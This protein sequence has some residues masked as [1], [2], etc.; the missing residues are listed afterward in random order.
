MKD[1]AHKFSYICLLVLLPSI[2]VSTTKELHM[3]SVAMDIPAVMY[4]RLL[5]LTRYLEKQL[6]I[7]VNLRLSPN[8]AAAIDEIA[9]KR[10]DIS[11]LT[12][13]AYLKAQQKGQA[14]L[15]AKMITQGR[16]SFQLMIVVS[17]SSP[18]KSLAGLQNRSFAFGDPAALL[19]RAV[20]VGAGIK[21]DD[22]AEVRFLGHYDNIVRGVM[23]GDFDAGVL[24]DT[25]AYKWENNGI[26]ILYRSPQLPPYNIVVHHDMPEK[27]YQRIKTAF[28]S[29]DP[30]NPQHQNIIKALDSK[31]TGFAETSDKEYDIIRKLIAPFT[32]T[33]N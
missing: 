6:N 29:L 3:G 4:K 18:I 12:P 8:M 13:V 32:M 30:N 9:N 24:K 25:L 23:N 20:V 10:V 15:V 28:L 5:P 22:F 1:I 27:L 26:R 19:Q 31:Y 33:D 11:Y 7:R 16:S 17:A 2:A 21:L 14:R